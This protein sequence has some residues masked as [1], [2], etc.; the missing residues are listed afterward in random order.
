MLVGVSFTLF[1]VLRLAVF[2][3]FC[4]FG[5]G[6]KY[7]TFKKF[8]KQMATYLSS[9]WGNYT[10]FQNV[11]A[12]HKLVWQKPK[13]ANYWY[14]CIKNLKWLILGKLLEMSHTSLHNIFKEQSWK[15]W[16]NQG[17]RKCINSYIWTFLYALLLWFRSYHIS[18]YLFLLL[19]MQGSRGHQ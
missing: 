8:L 1:S 12:T 2:W 18:S 15:T 7:S 9:L 11:S 4:F 3:N 10:S 6:N 14:F 13:F 19:Q 16:K 5:F 17:F